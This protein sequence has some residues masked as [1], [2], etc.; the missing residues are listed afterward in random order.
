MSNVHGLRCVVTGAASGIGRA[1]AEQLIKGGATVVSLDRNEP[2]VPVSRHIA[3]DLSEPASIDEAIGQLGSG[4]DAHI[5]V[6][7]VPGT[8][9]S[10]LV[11]K[12]NFL[13]LRHLTEAMFDR[14]EPGGAIVNVSSTAGFGWA[15]RLDSIRDLL[16]AD[17]FE[18]GLE[19]F[20]NHPQEG[21]IYNF[22]KEC[23]TVY[24]MA[25]ATGLVEQNVRMNAI[26]PGPVETPILADFE[27]TMGKDNL[28]GV[29]FLLGRH[30][31]PDDIAGP[32]LFLI[33]PESR[34]VNGHALV[35]DGGITGAVL[36]GLVP[37]PEI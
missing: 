16:T 37:A 22:S 17:T 31:S 4:F 13:G 1:V 23:V 26:L 10:E 8:A 6:A 25:M 33:S 12:V 20:R 11:F 18:S 35:V 15:Q 36:S 30:A 32:I 7:G 27:E 29:K 14:L 21:N 2:T 19:W 28:D 24:T 34:W 5:N 9:S 3:V